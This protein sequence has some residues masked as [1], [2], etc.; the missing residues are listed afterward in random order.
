MASNPAFFTRAFDFVRAGFWLRHGPGND[1]GEVSAVVIAWVVFFHAQGTEG[2]THTYITQVGFEECVVVGEAEPFAG[3]IPHMNVRSSA[4]RP[5]SKR[6]RQ[7]TRVEV[8]LQTVFEH[9]NNNTLS[10]TGTILPIGGWILRA[11]D[12]HDFIFARM[13]CGYTAMGAML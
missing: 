3:R 9:I 2:N 5:W 1:G 11:E 7:V 6:R 13:E 8:L 10:M 4:Q 12:E